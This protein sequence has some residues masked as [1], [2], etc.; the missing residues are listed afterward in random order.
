MTAVQKKKS[1][2]RTVLVLGGI[3]AGMFAFG[4][5]LVPLYQVFCNITG[6]N[7]SSQGRQAITEYT[8]EVDRERLITVQF[9]A[10]INAGLPV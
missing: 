5:A 10:T 1:N 7:G 6:F 4:F 2:R 8:G 9:D 3:V